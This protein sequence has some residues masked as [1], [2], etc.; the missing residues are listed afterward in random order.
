VFSNGE[1][2][3]KQHKVIAPAFQ[4]KNLK[5]I[6]KLT[7]EPVVELLMEEWKKFDNKPIQIAEWMQRF[8]LDT[9][10]RAA[11][12]FDLGS[13]KVISFILRGPSS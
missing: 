13:V 11:F 8:T 3:K 10:G 4:T 1:V 12:S 2:W 9:L 7:F 5:R 6:S